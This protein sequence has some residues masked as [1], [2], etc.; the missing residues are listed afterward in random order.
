MLRVIV[1]HSHQRFI[2]YAENHPHVGWVVRNLELVGL[3]VFRVETSNEAWTSASFARGQ[4][5]NI[6]DERIHRV[7][8]RV[9]HYGIVGTLTVKFYESF[10]LDDTSDLP[11]VWLIALVQVY[12]FGDFGMAFGVN[13]ET[14]Q[15]K[16]SLEGQNFVFCFV[17]FLLP[18]WKSRVDE[19]DANFLL[20]MQLRVKN[21][22]FIF[23]L[24]RFVRDF[25]LEGI[26]LIEFFTV[27]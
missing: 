10:F 8:L 5:I 20:I 11:I 2:F 4:A 26:S 27:A 1:A 16:V 9:Y 24:G 15:T 12:S 17:N 13:F 21:Y 18:F 19:A 25:E 6:I 23:S 7:K 14:S 22:W 3:Q